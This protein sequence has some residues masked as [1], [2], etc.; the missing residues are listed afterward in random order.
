MTLNYEH[1]VHEIQPTTGTNFGLK[2]YAARR[3]GRLPGLETGRGLS[4]LPAYA[5]VKQTPQIP[6][7]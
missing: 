2:G 3:K 4:A 7:E 1:G 6:G 5:G